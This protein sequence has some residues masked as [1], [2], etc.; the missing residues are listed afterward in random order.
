MFEEAPKAT[1]DFRSVARVGYTVIILTFG[2]FGGWAATARLDSAVIA[3]GLVSVESKRKSVQ[4]LEGG[5]VREINVTDGKEV[6]EGDVLFRLDST[7]SGANYEATRKQL[8]TMLATEARLLAERDQAE[9][10]TFPETLTSR[11][12]QPDVARLLSDQQNQFRE[13]LASINGQISLM[14]SRIDQY[15]SEID[16]L[17]RERASA[18]QQLFF[19][20]DELVGVKSLA[21]RGLV[22]KSRESALQ[23][24]KARLDGVVGRNQADRAKA[25]NSISETEIQIRQVHQKFQEEVSV[26]LAET[27]QRLNDLH[28]RIRIAEDVLRRIDVVA[29]Q[30]GIVHNLKVFTV[31]G[32]IRPGDTLL[33][34]VPMND[35][36]VVEAQVQVTDVDRIHPGL[37]AEVRFPAF[38]SRTTPVIMGTLRDI[39]RDRL[40]DEATR[41]PYYLA[42]VAV[43]DTDLPEDL[44]ERLRPG[45]PSEVIFPSGE[46]TVFDYLTRPLTEAVTTSFRER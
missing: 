24:E 4:H 37:A 7:S 18:S 30:S 45:M 19:I 43:R 25:L 41:T 28:E 13:R 10:V 26:Q 27:R 39:S 38:H 14:Q 20:E 15:R 36:L 8:D 32:V 3:S 29:P 11:A 9:S 35:E 16:G 12:D 2:I 40:V 31:G 46:R 22:A 33:E 5:I 34:I 6:Q 42:Q 44:K 1:S 23:R 17:E 21:E